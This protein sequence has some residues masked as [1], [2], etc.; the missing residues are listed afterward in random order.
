MQVIFHGLLAREFQSSYKVEVD[1]VYEAVRA[2]EANTGRFYKF[3]ADKKNKNLF[4]QIFIEKNPVASLGE[5]D[6][7]IKHKKRIH[8]FPVVRGNMTNEEMALYGAAGMAVGWGLDQLGGMV[9]GWFGAAL[10]FVGNILF[11][12][13]ASLLLQ[14]AINSLMPDVEDPPTIEDEAAVMKSTQSFTF[15][16]P[17]NNIQQGAPVPVGYGRLRVGSNVISSHLLNSRVAAFNDIGATME[18][19]NGNTVGAITVDQYRT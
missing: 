18:D 14:G 19:E 15:Q 13:G 6:L 8:F 10:S 3:L 5:L 7:S 11:E 12:V 17:I 9:G 2:I 16:Q 4:F 1:S